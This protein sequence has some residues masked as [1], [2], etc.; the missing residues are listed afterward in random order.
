MGIDQY[1]LYVHKVKAF[2][3]PA[4]DELNIIAEIDDASNVKVM[5]ALGKFIG[6]YKIQNTKVV[7]NTSLLPTGIYFY[8]VCD[9]NDRTLTKGKFNR[10]R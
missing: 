7:I 2:P 9:K 4:K 5:D 1:D 8:D 10:L 6:I 3:N